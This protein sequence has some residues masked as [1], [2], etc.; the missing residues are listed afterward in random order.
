MDI[1]EKNS[2][3]NIIKSCYE[4]TIDTFNKWT[5]YHPEKLK[6][7]NL[8]GV[9][10]SYLTNKVRSVYYNGDRRRYFVDD[11]RKI[12]INAKVENN[13][14]L[15]YCYNKYGSSSP[16]NYQYDKYFSQ[17]NGKYKI[18]EKTVEQEQI[19]FQLIIN[20]LNNYKF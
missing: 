16:L 19:N 2:L 15:V 17:Y 20:K 12:Q 14:L 3:E 13:K 4:D 10:K 7:C 5:I 6:N 9:F 18:S 11:M 1:S 8:S